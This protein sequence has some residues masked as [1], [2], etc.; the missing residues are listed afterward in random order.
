MKRYQK[1]CILLAVLMMVGCAPTVRL[2]TP[3]PVKI[4][5]NMKVD[6]YTHQQE[7]SGKVG[8][9]ED[10]KSPQE[11]RRG[12]MPE[13]QKLKNDRVIGEGIDGYLKIKNVPTDPVYADYAQRIISQENNDRRKIFIEDGGSDDKPV[14]VIAR[15]FAKRAREASFPG[16]WVQTDSGEWKE[17]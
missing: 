8:K 14:E 11:K 10:E 12:R 13:V 7:S 9:K 5:V 3:E 1:Y 17:K 4:D 15:E 2:D 6:I 16:E